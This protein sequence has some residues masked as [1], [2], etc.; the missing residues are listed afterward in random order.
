MGEILLDNVGGPDVITKSLKGRRGKQ[1]M[2]MI[3][4]VLF[5]PLLALRM[6]ERGYEAEKADSRKNQGQILTSNP[7]KEDRP[8]N[9]L[10]L[11]Q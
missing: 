4:Q 2:S 8:A 1:N 3:G 11:A 6:E 7:Q 10:I 9:I 5:V